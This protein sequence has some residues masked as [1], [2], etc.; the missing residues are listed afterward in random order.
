[1]KYFVISAVGDG[2]ELKMMREALKLGT[3]P[4]GNN[5]FSKKFRLFVSESLSWCIPVQDTKHEGAKLRTRLLKN[6]L[7]LPFGN[8]VA[9][10]ADL[11]TLMDCVSKDKHL[12]RERDWLQEDKMNYDAVLRLCRPKLR[13][14]LSIHVPGSEATC[15]YLKRCISSQPAILK[16]S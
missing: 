16:N 4:K 2:R 6:H 8:K 1:M 5:Q 11:N 7:L 9:S 13:K 12:L 14:L 15:F 10:S 3:A